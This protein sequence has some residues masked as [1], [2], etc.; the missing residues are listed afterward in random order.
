MIGIVGLD[1]NV[2]SSSGLM[3]VSSTSM[4]GCPENQTTLETMNIAPRSCLN[5]KGGMTKTAPI[6][7][8]SSARATKDTGE[9]TGGNGVAVRNELV[10]GGRSGG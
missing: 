7:G 8:H 5:T 2:L 6:N 3:E 1:L 9:G 4:S 10:N